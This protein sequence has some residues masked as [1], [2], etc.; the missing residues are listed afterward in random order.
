[1]SG[2]DDRINSHSVVKWM[3]ESHFNAHNIRLF[4]FACNKTRNESTLTSKIKK[5]C[6]YSC[7]KLCAQDKKKTTREKIQR[8]RPH[9]KMVKTKKKK[10]W[11]REEEREMWR[12]IRIRI[13]K[14]DYCYLFVVLHLTVLCH[15]N[16]LTWNM[17]ASESNNLFVNPKNMQGKWKNE[18]KT[19]LQRVQSQSLR[20]LHFDADK[21]VYTRR[22]RR[23]A[24]VFSPFGYFSIDDNNFCSYY[25]LRFFSLIILSCHL[26]FCC[27]FIKNTHNG[28]TLSLVFIIKICNF[29]FTFFCSP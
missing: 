27:Q 19:W 5:K 28:E 21:Y 7:I 20:R 10:S 3:N 11:M 2:F 25:G 4:E 14:I 22:S 13:H 15:A 18:Q 26:A 6:L 23:S 8:R 9:K 24:N 16:H 1:M 12:C 17:V 29:R